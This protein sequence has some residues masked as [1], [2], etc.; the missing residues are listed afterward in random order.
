MII[1]DFNYDLE[2]DI[3][4]SM[5]VFSFSFIV[6]WKNSRNAT[7]PVTVIHDQLRCRE[8]HQV[9]GAVLYSEWKYLYGE[10]IKFSYL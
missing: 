10:L 9:K 1:N 7:M 5:L 3:E 8:W 6:E 2:R 4:Y